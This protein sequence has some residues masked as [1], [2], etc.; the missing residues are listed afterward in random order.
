MAQVRD[1][2]VDPIVAF[3]F[4][5]TLTVRDSFAAFILWRTASLKLLFGALRLVPAGL[6]Y[7]IHRDR[8]RV[9]SAAVK[10]FLGGL[11]RER[12]AADARRFA[13]SQADR[14]LRPDALETWRRWRAEPVQLVI[15]T[16]SPEILVA[17][18]AEILG[19]DRLLGTP[20]T[21]DAQGR[22]TGAFDSP[23]CRA[24][25]KVVRLRAAFGQDV[26]LRAAYGDTSGDAEMLAIAEEPG[27]RV[28]TARP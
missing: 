28:F 10:V 26:R 18:F 22:I 21:C 12:L 6:G 24:A 17:P 25:E 7:L 9:K 11:T 19:A 1:S 20:L 23:N 16:A 3:D 8:G 2:V 13:E 27:F 15:V 4:D 5:G 14:L